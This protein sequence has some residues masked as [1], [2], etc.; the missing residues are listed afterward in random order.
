LKT[1]QDLETAHMEISLLRKVLS[2]ASELSAYTVRA[3]RKRPLREGE[4]GNNC[5]SVVR[6]GDW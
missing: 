5:S 1:S 6:L 3:A 2:P 4:C